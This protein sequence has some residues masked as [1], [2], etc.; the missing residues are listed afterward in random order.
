MG[1]EG[2]LLAGNV[3]L[4]RVYQKERRTT[5]VPL[6]SWWTHHHMCLFI[7]V[8]TAVQRLLNQVPMNNI[9]SSMVESTQRVYGSRLS[10]VSA[11]TNK[12]HHHHECLL[13]SRLP[14]PLPARS[15]SLL[16]AAFRHPPAVAV[17]GDWI[18]DSMAQCSSGARGWRVLTESLRGR[19]WQ[20]QYFTRSATTMLARS[21]PAWHL[22]CGFVVGGPF[23]GGLSSVL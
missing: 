2:G 23:V 15:C 1:T 19:K 22:S 3:E 5:I 10:F 6:G 11:R 8:C 4:C 7:G 20:I 9:I 17:S 21:P 18:F 16:V 13:F 12:R 14:R